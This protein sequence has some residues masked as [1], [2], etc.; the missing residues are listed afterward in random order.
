MC[1]NLNDHSIGYSTNH[2]FSEG[3]Q[4]F[5]IIFVKITCPMFWAENIHFKIK[6]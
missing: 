1:I 2:G 5:N 4:L 6:K 3:F